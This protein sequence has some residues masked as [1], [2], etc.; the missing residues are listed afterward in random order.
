MGRTRFPRP[1][2]ALLKLCAL[3]GIAALCPGCGRILCDLLSAPPEALIITA[4]PLE[5]SRF[6]GG[7]SSASLRAVVFGGLAPFTYRWSVNDPAG[8]SAGELLNP[9]SGSTTRFMPGPTD[10][11]YEVLC[12]VTDTCGRKRTSRRLLRV[13]RNVGLDLA[14]ARFGIRVGGG[15][16]GKVTIR[17]DPGLDAPPFDV[18][19][20]CTT[21]DGNLDNDRLDTADPLA[22][23]FTSRHTRGTHVL[24]AFITDSTGA[25]A[26][27]SAIVIVGA[28]QS[29][30][31]VADRAAVAPGGGADGLARLLATPVGGRA[32]FTYDWQIVGPDGTTRND[33]LW[34]TGARSPVFES[35]A[36][37]GVF[38]ARCAVTDALHTV[39]ISM[40]TIEV[41]PR[42]A[43]A[44]SAD[45]HTL[46]VDDPDHTSV[47]VTADARGGR[48]PIS[49]AWQVTGPDGTDDTALITPGDD[50][51]A[52]FTH[53]A[54][55]GA[56]LIRCTATD[57][58]RVS[59]AGAVV[60]TVGGSL[61]VTLESDK[62]SLT[63]GGPPTTRT[64]RLLED[65]YG[66][67][68]PFTFR[69]SVI[70]PDGF[71]IPGLLSA[72]N[73]SNPRF[74]GTTRVGPFTVLCEVRDA[75]GRI[76]VD[77]VAINVGQP[78]NADLNLLGPVVANGGGVAGQ[79]QV[80]STVHGGSPP[81]T[82]RW[83]ATDPSGV[84]ASFRLS[85][86]DVAGPAFTSGDETGTY[87]FTLTATDALGAVF[88]E[89]AELTVGARGSSGQSSF[90]ID[91]SVNRQTVSPAGGTAELAVTTIGGLA[92]LSYQW[93]ITD[94]A[95]QPDDDRLDSTTAT[96]VT[97]TADETQGT[98]RIR[99]TVTDAAGNA[100]TD[101]VQLTVSDDFNLDVRAGVTHVAPGGTVEIIADRSGGMPDFTYA[102]TAVDETDK[103]AGTFATDPTG[104]G[105][106]TQTSP[107]DAANVWTAPSPDSGIVGTFRLTVVATDATGSSFTDSV[108]INV[109][110]AFL[111]DLTAS[112]AHV[113]PGGSV[114]LTVDRTGGTPDF[115]Y[116]WSA[117][118]PIGNPAGTFTTGSTGPGAAVQQAADDDTN[119]WTAPA[120]GTGV[121]GDHAIT[122]VADDASG[123]SFT[124]TVQVRVTEPFSIHLAA[125]NPVIVPG[126]SA[127]LVADRFGGEAPFSYQW[128]ARD[129]SGTLA[130]TF[131]TG[132]TDV[133]SAVQNALPDDAANTWVAPTTA[134]GV[135]ETYTITTVA[136]DR[137]GSTFT[138]AV[139]FV[140]G[141]DDTLTIDVT[142][143]NVFVAPG[144]PV[145]LTVRPNGAAS[146]TTYT[147]TA[148]NDAGAS[149]GTLAATTQTAGAG[150][151]TNT[152][153]APAAAAGTLGTY[154]ITVTATDTTGS[155][156][157]DSV[158]VVVRSFLSLDLTAD[159]T[160]V[161]PGANVTLRADQTGGETTYSYA[162]S[163]VDDAGNAAGTFSTGA[164]GTGAAA[165]TNQAGDASNVW[166]AAVERGYT[167]TCTVTDATGQTF[168]DSV[169]VVVTASD[170]FSLNVTADKQVVA[171][172]ET[173]N[174]TGDRTGGTATFNYA[175][176]A[177]D[178]AGAT[179]GTLGA[180][181]QNAQLGDV[182]NTWIAPTSSTAGGT[183]RIN[184]T[185]TDAAARSFTD[186][187][188]V[189]VST[190]AVQNIFL[191]PVA[192]T[193]SNVLAATLISP[194]AANADPGQQITAGL[195]NPPDPRNVVITIVDVNNSITGGTARVTGLDARGFTQSEVITIAPTGG[196]SSTN[197]GAAPFAVVT[198]VD[199][200][201][202][203]GVTAFVDQIAVGLGGKFGLTS[204]IQTASD[205]LYV[206]EG[207]TV[208]TSGFTV[209]TTTATQGITFAAPPDGTR[210]YIVVFRAR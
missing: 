139:E 172:G 129:S 159:D 208:Q 54:R 119:V 204:R 174:L 165:Q 52:V 96:D 26:V 124:A 25:S 123:N 92:P 122:V 193:I 37:A 1:W 185:I 140:V 131:T 115:T 39:S 195:T 36:D 16:A 66:G 112:A 210:N 38:S 48:Q 73:I 70:N 136:T 33:L 55:V 103:A 205:I 108:V 65:I 31:V 11:P 28:S 148:I 87:Q 142:A 72:I 12:T 13:G 97:F 7:P 147:W 138:D 141:A 176:T 153:T 47:T 94:P 166:S 189:E 201:G 134:P 53:D 45:H 154:R 51:Q 158:H 19:W 181:A 78:L 4:D 35:A 80:F 105:A 42:I 83:R 58:G 146:T 30:D 8:R 121:F 168:T 169:A 127:N 188:T 41:T 100:A 104:P 198:Q 111:I 110:N 109:T 209:D 14:A 192:G 22:P 74:L 116:N 170:V 76:A 173:V 79:T 145:N 21:P 17:I 206:N 59:A 156:F 63:V 203:T 135:R 161:T 167:I 157:T 29:V 118:D 2:Q 60:L 40:T 61:G 99:C 75:G 199:L 151:T 132:P 164:S 175:W 191:A 69:W 137:F 57:A 162:W 179:G 81:Y 186:G 196:G 84:S 10:G 82:Y 93:S 89:T 149:A 64:A 44:V 49:Y 90:S 202:M 117:A 114:N 20:M 183:Y 130:G 15:P 143:D 50:G 120:A 113:L 177:V 62:A 178:A 71:L 101:S 46:P 43:V 190:S 107:D 133:G 5:L 125:G 56:Y 187:V 23:I 200:F 163:A 3:G 27:R 91:V 86:T 95:G 68:P 24:T 9:V 77:D 184:C 207:G 88:V 182:T 128:T 34:D 144:A 150:N 18:R 106:A 197:T 180:A 85:D 6:P 32:P 152:W 160:F 126:A 67:T 98:F 155:T 102:W 194:T 171:P